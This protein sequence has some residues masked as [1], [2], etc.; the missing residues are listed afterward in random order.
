MAVVLHPCCPPIRGQHLRWA[1]ALLFHLA[2]W[3][4]QSQPPKWPPPHV[5]QETASSILQNPRTEFD[6]LFLVDNS[7]TM[8]TKQT[9]LA[10]NL[11]RM[12]Q[13]LHSDILTRQNGIFIFMANMADPGKNSHGK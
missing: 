9:A 1:L 3:A 10:K 7:P 11:P 4:C 5:G 13:V 6:I 12:I 2:L 8:A